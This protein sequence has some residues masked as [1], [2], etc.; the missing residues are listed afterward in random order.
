ME[1]NSDSNITF[2]INN[3]KKKEEVNQ[4]KYLGFIIDKNLKIILITYVRRSAKNQFF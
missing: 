4:I 1:L 3:Q 2:K